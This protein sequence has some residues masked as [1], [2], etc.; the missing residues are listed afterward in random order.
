M[1]AIGPI[2]ADVCGRTELAWASSDWFRWQEVE[3]PPNPAGRDSLTAGLDG[4]VALVDEG[5]GE[6]LGDQDGLWTSRDGIEWRRLGFGVPSAHGLVALPG[7]V[8]T[9]GER[10]RDMGIAVWIGTPDG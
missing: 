7:R 4:L 6:G 3:G 5:H 1:A 2:V 9:F 10:P 8:I